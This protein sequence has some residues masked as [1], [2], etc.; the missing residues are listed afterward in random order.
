VRQAATKVLLAL[1]GLLAVS[2]GACA[3]APREVH[4]PRAYPET[5][6]A[7]SVITLEVVDSRAAPTTPGQ[8]QLLLPGDF[9]AVAQGR[10]TG[11][12]TGQ[13]PALHVMAAVNGGEAVDITDARGEVTRVSVQLDFEVKVQDGPLLR[14]G[15]SQSMSDLPRDEA[16]PEEINLLLRSTSIDAFDRYW[17]DAKTTTALNADLAAYGRQQSKTV[18]P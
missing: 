17:A 4:E 10:V 2:L 8:R 9:E 12:L 6:L 14:R 13:G 11:M 1:S 3:S 15:Q 5:K 18:S 7:A 16:T